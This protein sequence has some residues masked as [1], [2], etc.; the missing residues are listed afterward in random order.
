M[1]E[2][3]KT[4]GSRGTSAPLAAPPSH[5]TKS[6]GQQAQAP[7]YRELAAV[8][9]IR[10][11]LAAAGCLTGVL[12]GGALNDAGAIVAWCYLAAVGVLLSYVDARTRLLPTRIIGPSYGVLAALLLLA[13]VR[14]GGASSLVRAGVGWAVVGGLYFLLWFL[15]PKGIG[16][17]DVR[18][19]GLLGLG[20]GYLGWSQL[21]TGLYAGFLLG[22]IGGAALLVLHRMPE[23]RYAFGPFMVTGALVGVCAGSLV[24]D[25]YVAMT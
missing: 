15:Y 10:S 16:Y 2:G 8:P 1:S 3:A 24:G 19:A 5:T 4:E 23:R 18:L 25:W 22:G 21:V 9:G 20:L 13:G 11:C 17:G 7:T 6:R 12:V 14:D